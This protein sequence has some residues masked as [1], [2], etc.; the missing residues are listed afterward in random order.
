MQLR[1]FAASELRHLLYKFCFLDLRGVK[2][3]K[4]SSGNV[5]NICEPTDFGDQFNKA[6]N[7]SFSYC[8]LGDQSELDDKLFE[9]GILEHA[10]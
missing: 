8:H 1:S 9:R 4:K 7:S 3:K 5:K 10:F 2:S 6:V